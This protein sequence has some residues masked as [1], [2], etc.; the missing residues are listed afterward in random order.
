MSTAKDRVRLTEAALVVLKRQPGV[1]PTEE[2]TAAIEGWLDMFLGEETSTP[3]R[4]EYFA[5]LLNESAKRNVPGALMVV[6][7]GAFDETLS[8]V[9]DFVTNKKP[10]PTSLQEAVV[11][12]LDHWRMV[13]KEEA[14]LLNEVNVP[15]GMVSALLS[16]RAL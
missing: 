16:G 2:D 1:P 13:F 14:R 7:P 6:K 15:P 3:P 5:T 10:I 12:Y 9:M 4:L 11:T 8:S